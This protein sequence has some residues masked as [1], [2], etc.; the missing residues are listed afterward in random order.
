M[1]KILTLTLVFIIILGMFAG[2]GKTNTP[3]ESI[4]TEPVVENTES[5][6]PTD[7]DVIISDRVDE[8]GIDWKTE[9]LETP[10]IFMNVEEKKVFED[11]NVINK[12]GIS[13]FK[14][15][16]ENIKAKLM[17]NTFITNKYVLAISDSEETYR[18]KY[19]DVGVQQKYH[20]NKAIVGVLKEDAED[21]EYFN[22]FAIRFYGDT[23][24]ADGYYLI[25]ISFSDIDI[26][27]ET[28]DEIYRTL[29]EF[30]PEN[31]VK[32]IV[33]GFDDDGCKPN[34]K[35]LDCVKD[36]Y[37][38]VED[39]NFKYKFTRTI[40]FAKEN[41]YPD[42]N[43]ISFTFGKEDVKFSNKF[44]HYSGDYQPQ[45]VD[46]NY[47]PDKFFNSAMGGLDITDFSTFLDE[48]FK[49]GAK[50]YIATVI[51]DD[52]Y[53][54]DRIVGDNGISK[55]EVA[56]EAVAGEENVALLV[57]PSLDVSY[58]VIEKDG[59]PIDMYFTI[60]NQSTNISDNEDMETSFKKLHNDM[61]E[62]IKCILGDVDLSE[63]SYENLKKD[64]E[65]KRTGKTSV[66]IT[67]Y[68]VEYEVDIEL[69]IG[70]NMLDCWR[71][72]FEL[73]ISMFK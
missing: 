5:T 61:I 22:D 21:S 36:M 41:G 58:T 54:Y 53:S 73:N 10:D 55:Y 66:T 13:N 1:K 29:S 37:V 12:I 63:I 44:E 27:L 67:Y 15:S 59:K 68:D 65:T 57:C 3:D 51:R 38:T 48:Y 30:F 32:Y 31:V 17:E 18:D 64:S 19:S 49:I 7:T 71:G 24:E 25:S 23:N 56:F 35:D 42:V 14:Y 6:E 2:C 39:D 72:A 46:M 28:Q 34:G 8:S 33:Y 20:Y 70:Q 43:K 69:R 52:W 50:D 9:E 11:Y 4:P 16:V 47:T 40:E 26:S 45:L 60:E 62:Q